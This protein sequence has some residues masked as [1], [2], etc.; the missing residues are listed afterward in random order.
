MQ[1]VGRILGFAPVSGT[2]LQ[3]PPPVDL[4]DDLPVLPPGVLTVMKVKAKPITQS[5]VT[6]L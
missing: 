6:E 5:E 1:V 2:F 3:S 4:F